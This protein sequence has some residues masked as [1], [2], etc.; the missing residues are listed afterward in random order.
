[1]YSVSH[2][3]SVVLLSSFLAVIRMGGF[4]VSR[5]ESCSFSSWFL[6][7]RRSFY[8]CAACACYT[9]FARMQVGRLVVGCGGDG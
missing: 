4:L 8:L 5:G 9:A 2:S 6:V 7:E 1:M 3:F